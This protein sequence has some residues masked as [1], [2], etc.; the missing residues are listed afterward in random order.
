MV[1]IPIILQGFYTVL[2]PGGCLG[3]LPSTAISLKLTGAETTGE[4]SNIHG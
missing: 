3:F 2:S 1:N 4:E